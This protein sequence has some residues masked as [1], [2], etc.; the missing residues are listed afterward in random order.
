MFPSVCIPFAL[1]TVIDHTSFTLGWSLLSNFFL[2]AYLLSISLTF[3]ALCTLLCSSLSPIPE[4]SFLFIQKLPQLCCYP[5]LIVREAFDFPRCKDGTHTEV[6]VFCDTVSDGVSV[7]YMGVTKH[8][9][10]RAS[11]HPCRVFFASC[12]QYLTVLV[13][14]AVEQRGSTYRR[15]VPDCGQSSQ[16]GIGWWSASL[17]FA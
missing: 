2:Y 11:K 8:I 14:A 3:S 15:E 4:G 16:V 10:V 9:P 7:L 13:A 12:D 6:D 17:T 1:N 5:G